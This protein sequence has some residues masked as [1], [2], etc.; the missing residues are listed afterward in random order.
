MDNV[1]NFNS[2]LF[3]GQMA[4]CAQAF[5]KKTLKQNNY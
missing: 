3:K 2:R 5:Y 4:E 1:E